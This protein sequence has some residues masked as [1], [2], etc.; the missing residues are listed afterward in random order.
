VAD[1]GEPEASCSEWH[2]DGTAGEDDRASHLVAEAPARRWVRS[3]QGDTSLV[4]R[5][6]GCACLR[7][8][9]VSRSLDLWPCLSRIQ[10]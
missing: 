4:G 9:P 8:W 7:S 10:R 5:C 6:R 3:V 1:R 2:G